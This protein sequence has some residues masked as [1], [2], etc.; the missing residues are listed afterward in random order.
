MPGV[1]SLSGEKK[2]PLE[3]LLSHSSAHIHW[4]YDLE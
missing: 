3:V 1:V 2:K 4:F